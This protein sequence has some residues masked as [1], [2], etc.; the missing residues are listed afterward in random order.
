MRAGLIVVQLAI[1]LTQMDT[2]AQVESVG[3]ARRGRILRQVPCRSV[4]K[5]VPACGVAVM[6]TATPRAIRRASLD[7]EEVMHRACARDRV[8]ARGALSPESSC[9]DSE[10]RALITF[11]MPSDTIRGASRKK[12]RLSAV[13]LSW[14][15]RAHSMVDPPSPPLSS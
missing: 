6:I 12:T 2:W 1:L 10:F 9:W 13:A 7:A 4:L 14:W 15:V 11:H 8:D 5:S 3:K